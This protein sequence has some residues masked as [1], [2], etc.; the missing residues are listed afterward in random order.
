MI[1][2]IG[3][4]TTFE[5]LKAIEPVVPK[6]AGKRWRAIRH[7]DLVTSIRD[8]VLR[9]G[10]TIEK[11]LFSTANNG[12]DM[13]GALQLGRVMTSDNVAV[14]VPSGLDLALGFV[15]SNDR[16]KALR[17]MAGANIACCTNGLAT[18]AIIMNR[19]HDHT[20]NLEAEVRLAVDKY[21][22]EAGG[23]TDVVKV[24]RN[25]ELVKGQASEILMQAG[26]RS[27]VGW[28]AIGRVDQE[29][30]NPTFAEHGKGTGWALMNAFSYAA[31]PNIAPRYQMET[32]DEF[33]R[34]IMASQDASRN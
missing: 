6:D 32:Y 8:E 22:T 1:T 33:R 30:R 3:S 20:V 24:L 16:R 23:V 25:M 12:A 34:M 15:H 17:L 2:V 14:E 19:A 18:G 13:V 27:L 4:G 9:R 31:R 21:I 7:D 10:W 28:A 26:R 11:E 5:D 29:F